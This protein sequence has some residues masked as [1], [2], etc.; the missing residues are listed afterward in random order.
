MIIVDV[1][2]S[3]SLRVSQVNY[4]CATP[5][6]QTLNVTI[7]TQKSSFLQNFPPISYG[8]ESTFN[9]S[10][11]NSSGLPIATKSSNQN[12]AKDSENI[13]TILAEGDHNHHGKQ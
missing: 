8:S 10:A 12:V 2:L 6:N 9:L 1:G 7:G 11:T 13:V 3:L 5:V 4:L